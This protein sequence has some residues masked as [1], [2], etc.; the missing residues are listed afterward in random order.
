[1]LLAKVIDL[2]EDVARFE[3]RHWSD[4]RGKDG[5]ARLVAALPTRRRR[6]AASRSPPR[7]TSDRAPSKRS[8]RRAS[9][10][11]LAPF[12]TVLRVDSLVADADEVAT[13][14]AQEWVQLLGTVLELRGPH[15]VAVWASPA[16]GAIGRLPMI[17]AAWRVRLRQTG[18]VLDALSSTASDRT[19]A[20]AAGKARTCISPRT[21]PSLYPQALCTTSVR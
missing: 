4:V 13:A 12:R 8:S 3:V 9:T 11:E 5:P 10:P 14:S 6:P 1:V 16:A 2:A 19:V 18:A 7:S 17:E 20:K 21:E 15:A